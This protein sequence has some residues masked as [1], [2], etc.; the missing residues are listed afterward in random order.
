VRKQEDSVLRE[1][2]RFQSDT[3]ARPPGRRR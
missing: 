3:Q 2:E 1:F